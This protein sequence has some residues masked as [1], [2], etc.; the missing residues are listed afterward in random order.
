MAKTVRQTAPA[1]PAL[2]VQQPERLTQHQEP[3]RYLWELLDKFV[4]DPDATPPRPADKSVQEKLR[5]EFAAARQDSDKKGNID[6]GLGR[7][8]V[9]GGLP[10]SLFSDVLDAESARRLIRRAD[11]FIRCAKE[12]GT[13]PT[14]WTREEARRVFELYKAKHRTSAK[15]SVM[16]ILSAPS[17][18]FSELERWAY[19]KPRITRQEVSEKLSGERK[20]RELDAKIVELETK[21]AEAIK[22]EDF[23]TAKAVSAQIAALRQELANLTT[24]A[25]PAEAVEEHDE[26][27]VDETPSLED[28]IV[29]LETKK[30][31]AIKAEDFDTAKAVSAQIAALRQAE[32]A[33]GETTAAAAPEPAPVPAPVAAP[34][35]MAPAAATQTATA[36]DTGS[37]D[38][39]VDDA[40]DSCTSETASSAQKRILAR[41]QGKGGKSLTEDEF[42]Y[43]AKI[44]AN[45]K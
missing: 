26:E 3:L 10:I 13:V 16:A 5:T 32:A 23:D 36:G 40:I 30:A 31:E 12:V 11:E 34:V 41:F 1:A 18:P 9:V 33:S 4:G 39:T 28:Q 20:I 8:V 22:A 25:A 2:E 17:S 19:P 38:F 27:E 45:A 29:E 15:R 35:A 7:L 37:S 21:K 43:K 14:A 6:A 24:A 44:L 42:L